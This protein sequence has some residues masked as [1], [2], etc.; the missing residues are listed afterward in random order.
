M[1]E[2]LKVLKEAFAWSSAIS[3][4][5]DSVEYLAEL[6]LRLKHAIQILDKKEDLK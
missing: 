6:R 4:S 3:V 5:G 1:E 2:I